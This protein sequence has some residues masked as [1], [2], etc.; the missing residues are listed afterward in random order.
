MTLV[1]ANG[2]VL[3]RWNV[4]DVVIGLFL[5]FL[6][7]LLYGAYLL[8]REAPPSLASVD[9]ARVRG[10]QEVRVTIHGTNLR[11]YMRV[12]FNEHQ[13]DSF[14]FVDS[15]QAVIRVR[16]LP[17]GVYDVILYDQGQ[18]RARMTKGLEVVPEPRPQT[19]LDVIGTFTAIPG[20]LAA[21]IQADATIDKVG[22]VVS[23]GKP[24]ASLTRTQIGPN[25][26]VGVPSAS[27]VNLP[28]IVRAACTLMVR[29]NVATCVVNET[30]LIRDSV[31]TVMTPAGPALFQIDQ[32]RTVGAASPVELR[33]RF[34]GERSV[35]ERMRTGHID[36]PRRNPFA[37]GAAIAQLSGVSRAA[38]S[39]VVSTLMSPQ[40]GETPAILAGDVYTIDAVLRATA[41]RSPDGWSYNGKV[42]KAGR[43]L[44]FHGDDYEVSGTILGV[45]PG[46][47]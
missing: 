29:G 46:K 47:S 10:E 1:D 3:G 25:E 31:M 23:V 12:S 7:P 21:R 8:F 17:S 20:D 34:A 37:G 33:V 9:P 18:E 30:S 43:A 38:A 45:T 4:V 32:V 5:L 15:T 44:I 2:R 24:E 27:A 41:E 42:L 35:I 40:M 22:T 26:L 11:P 16:N 36:M 14:Q 39:T 28:A 19:T 6:I 13:G